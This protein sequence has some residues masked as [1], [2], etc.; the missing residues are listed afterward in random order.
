MENSSFSLKAIKEVAD[1]LSDIQKQQLPNIVAEKAT[2]F[3]K[4]TFVTKEWN[5]VLWKA[6]NHPPKR[7]SLMD[8]SGNLVNSIQPKSVSPEQIVISAG[9]SK[10]P[11]AKIHNEGGIIRHPGGERKMTFKKYTKGKYAGKTLF[12]KNN[13]HATFGKKVTISGHEINMPKRQFMGDS[14]QLAEQ[15]KKDIET[16]FKPVL[17]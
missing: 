11:Y 2:A 7:G 15:L 6:A 10:V 5:G 3:F 12:H 16:A 17:K 9:N 14:S 8:R 13:Q 1:R 4:H